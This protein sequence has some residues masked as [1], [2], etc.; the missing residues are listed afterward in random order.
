MQASIDAVRSAV[1][2]A[3]GDFDTKVMRPLQARRLRDASHSLARPPSRSVAAARTRARS[4][5]A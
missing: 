4:R 3:V 2:G 5:A 1:D